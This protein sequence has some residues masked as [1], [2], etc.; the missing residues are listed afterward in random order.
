[1]SGCASCWYGCVALRKNKRYKSNKKRNKDAEE[2]Q[3]LFKIQNKKL[4]RQEK[5]N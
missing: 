3:Y 1:M 2:W 5:L 4:D